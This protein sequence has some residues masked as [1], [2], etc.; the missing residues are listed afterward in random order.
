MNR[1]ELVRAI[2]RKVGLTQPCVAKVLKGYEAVIGETLAKD[3]SV[4]ILGF[5]TYSVSHRAPRR[6]VD[7][8]TKKEIV[9]PACTLA[10]F[11]PGTFLK[12]YLKK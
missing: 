2:S 5:G 10:K 8:Q 4:R 1:K 3:E 6:G 12:A 7:P 11:A 9:I